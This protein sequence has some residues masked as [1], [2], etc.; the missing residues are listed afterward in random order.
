MMAKYD[1]TNRHNVQ[2]GQSYRKEMPLS[3][4]ES[5]RENT[6]TLTLLSR[7]M[8]LEESFAV[9]GGIHMLYLII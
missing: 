5:S 7:T 2:L 6:P 8:R 1:N 4:Q 3:N 9:L